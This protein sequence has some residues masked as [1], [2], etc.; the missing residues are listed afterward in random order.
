MRRWVSRKKLRAARLCESNE[1]AEKIEA[2]LNN[3]TVPT[4]PITIRAGNC[5]IQEGSLTAD[6]LE[7]LGW[8]EERACVRRCTPVKKVTDAPLA[9]GIH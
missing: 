1:A 6:I 9:R 5:L 8:I 7:F 3:I 2:A 4:G